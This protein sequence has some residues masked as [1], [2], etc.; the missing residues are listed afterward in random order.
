MKVRVRFSSFIFCV[1]LCSFLKKHLNLNSL[2]KMYLITTFFKVSGRVGWLLLCL[3]YVFYMTLFLIIF[4]LHFP[5]TSLSPNMT[6]VT[7]DIWI[8]YLPWSSSPKMEGLSTLFT[9]LV[10]V[11]FLDDRHKIILNVHITVALVR[12]GIELSIK[13][14]LFY[15]FHSF[16]FIAKTSGILKLRVHRSYL[17]TWNY[18]LQN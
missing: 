9:G 5:L 16:V 6:I 10:L 13:L 3:W 12:N 11:F 1:C 8:A 7:C 14:S 18:Y 4:F 2:L 15:N 17:W